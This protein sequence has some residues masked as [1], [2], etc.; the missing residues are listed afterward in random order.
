[1][2]KEFSIPTGESIKNVA[3]YV[4]NNLTKSKILLLNGDLGAGKTALVKELAKLIGI[5][6]NITSPTFNYMKDYEGLIHIDAYHL[7]DDL[8]EFEDYYLDNIVAIE[9]SDNITHNYSN[10][11][12]IRIKLDSNNNHIFQIKEVE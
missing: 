4:L 3:I 11:L 7:S 1:M 12:D 10:Y 5:T 6:E 8:S 9:W 2:T